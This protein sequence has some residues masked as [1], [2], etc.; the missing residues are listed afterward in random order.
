M[1]FLQ[2][3]RKPE[4]FGGVLMVKGMNSGAHARLAKWGISHLEIS[5]D[6]RILDAGCGGGANVKRLL[7]LC[8]ESQVTGLDYSEISV[9]E[10]RKVNRAAIDAG[11]C[12]I[13]QGDVSHL[14]FKDG[15]FDLVTAFETIYFWPDMPKTFE[16]IYRVLKT[17]GTFFICNESNGHDEAAVHYSGIIEGM[18]LYD[19]QDIRDL[20]TTA[21]FR[22]IRVDQ[23]DIWLCVWGRKTE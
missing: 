17:G 9:G 18:K 7:D 10:S 16:G 13:V 6:A 15:T 3:T 2:N 8:P 1:S 5:Q 12:N 4:G 20:M 22:D 14:P 11:R 19:R 23:K 21:G